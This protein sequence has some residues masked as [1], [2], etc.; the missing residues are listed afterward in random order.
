[1]A[2][3]LAE[4]QG[5]C[6]LPPPLSSRGS[7]ATEA[8]PERSRRVT[9]AVPRSVGAAFL[10]RS[11]RGFPGRRPRCH[12][13]RSERI[14]PF[15]VPRR[16]GACSCPSHPLPPRSPPRTRP[17]AHPLTL[18][19]S[20]TN[21]RDLVRL[22]RTVPSASSVALSEAERESV[23]TQMPSLTKAIRCCHSEGTEESRR[24][25]PV[26]PSGAKRS[27]G[28]STRLV[29]HP[30]LRPSCHHP[31]PRTHPQSV[32]PTEAEE[33]VL[34]TMPSLAKAIQP[35]PSPSTHPNRLPSA[36]YAARGHPPSHASAPAVLAR[37]ELYPP[38]F[39]RV[40]RPSPLLGGTGSQPVGRGR[41][42]SP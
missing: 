3:R 24:P 11:I 22:P 35:A 15:A 29:P 10:P 9:P 18:L 2:A 23:P 12:A 17:S 8:C 37:T 31:S 5:R 21:V 30:I 39:R 19:S 34:Q 38:S 1:M 42:H 33:S 7:E 40:P 28:T 16:A 36:S 20:R 25:P 4:R 27:R 6:I 41:S 32:I 14:P 26:I 13:E